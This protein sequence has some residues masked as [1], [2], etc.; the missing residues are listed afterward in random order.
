MNA[1]R[2]T[3]RIH[4]NETQFVYDWYDFLYLF[5]GFVDDLLIDHNFKNYPNAKKLKNGI[6][7]Y[8]TKILPIR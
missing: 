5:S 4:W 6:T 7:H 8:Q 3:V 1:N 2:E